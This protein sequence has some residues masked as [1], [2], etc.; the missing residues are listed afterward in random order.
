VYGSAYVLI[1]VKIVRY[2]HPVGGQHVFLYY[3]GSCCIDLIE[4]TD[5]AAVM[6]LKTAIVST[7]QGFGRKPAPVLY[8]DIRTD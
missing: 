3:Y 2:V 8:N 5:D 4:V 7:C 1:A 6:N